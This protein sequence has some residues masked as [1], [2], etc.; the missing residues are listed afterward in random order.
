MTADKLRL[1]VLTATFHPTIGGA[2]T[3][4]FEVSRSL[5]QA[6]HEVFVVTDLPRGLT[7]GS[8]IVGDPPNVTVIRLSEHQQIANDPSRIPWEHCAFGLLPELERSCKGLAPNMVLSNSLDTALLAKVVELE[9][10]IPWVAT[11]HE[12]APEIDALGTGRLRLVY[13]VL[14]PHLV[15]AGS[16]HYAARASRW[17][18]SDRVALI[19]HGVDIEKFHPLACGD[20]VRQ[21][22]G[23]GP[24]E[25]LIVCA[26]R[27]KQRK[28]MHDLVRAFG[29]IAPLIPT[30][31]LLIVGTVNS[32]SR[33]YAIQ[34]RADAH[35]LG[36]SSRVLLDETVTFAEMPSVLAAADIVAQPSLEEGL[37]LSV[38]EA[39]ASAKAVITTDIP[40]IREI[41]T[42]PDVALIV[43][44]GDHQ[45]LAEAIRV[46]IANAPLRREMGIRARKHVEERFARSRMASQ[47][48]SAL[49]ALLRRYR[50]HVR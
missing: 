29:C 23:I 36:V 37:G 43:P 10:H 28:G 14:L 33:D 39:M 42:E 16:E 30:A 2:E 32:A 26:G 6:G 47:T 19:Y 3:Y 1:L 34:L 40:G 18:C 27:L 5:A 11:F 44:P 49:L 17:G 9:K 41:T 21:R 13:E 38:I 31:R 24:E 12:Q 15:L 35:Q 8:P 22:Y 46:L 45:A 7:A 50:G 20:K 4:A 25:H 48:E